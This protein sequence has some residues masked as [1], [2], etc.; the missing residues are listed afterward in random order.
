MICRIRKS[1]WSK[2][3]AMVL[4]VQLVLP[5][6]PQQV[7]A[8][9]G[10]P[11]QPE[12]SSFTP[13][14]VSDM[15]N[16][17]TGDF[18]YNI[19]L[20]DV[21]GYPI[22]LSYAGGIGMEQQA[23]NV[24][25]GWT[26]NAGGAISRTMRGI[27]DDFNAEDKIIKRNNLRTNFT[28]GA[29]LTL[30]PEILGKEFNIGKTAAK[31]QTSLT[32]SVFYNTYQ[33]IGYSFSINPMLS[34]QA[35]EK[36][37]LN[38][39]LGVTANSQSGLSISP[40]VGMDVTQSVTVKNETVPF[41]GSLGLGATF[42]S[43]AGLKAISLTGGI[44]SV[45]KTV[46]TTDSEGNSKTE[47]IFGSKLGSTIPIGTTTYIPNVGTGMF[48]SSF[49]C[50]F[51]TGLEGFWANAKAQVGGYFNEQHLRDKYREFPAAGYLYADGASG[52]NTMHDFN[53]EKDGSVTEFTPHIAMA[54]AT[55]DIYNV[56]G[57]G[58]AGMYRP[59]RDP[60][61]VYDPY[62]NS[63]SA[64]GSIGAD[65]GATLYFKGGFNLSFNFN[66]SSSGKWTSDR[67]TS[68]LDYKTADAVGAST[69]LYEPFYF[70]QAGEFALT[71]EAYMDDIGDVD[72]LRIPINADGKALNTSFKRRQNVAS[73]SEG[74]LNVTP[75][76]RGRRDKRTQ[77]MSALTAEIASE[78]GIET[79][80]LHFGAMSDSNDGTS[81]A[82]S[83]SRTTQGRKDH[84]LSEITINRNDGARYVY[85]IQQY[86]H[87]QLEVSFN[88]EDNSKDCI[89][90]F[91]DI[92]DNTN[93]FGTPK[94]DNTV[95][96]KK[97]INHFFNSTEMPPYS[98]AFLLT[99]VLSADYVDI[100]G[101]GPSDDDIGKYT[102]FN[103]TRVN[104]KSDPY[105]WR[106]PY[107][108]KQANFSEGFSSKVQDNKGNYIY[109][110]KEIWEV[111]SIV[112][113][114]HV[115]E[116][117]YSPRKD[118]FDADGEDGGQGDNTLNKLDSVKLFTKCDRVESGDQAV[119]LKTVH[120]EYDYSLCIG[121]PSNDNSQTL[122]GN[123]LSNGGG[124]LTL[125]KVY[126]TYADSKKGQLSPYQFGYA[127]SNHDLAEETALNPPYG[128]R[129]IDRWGNYKEN[130]GGGTPSCDIDHSIPS[131]AEFP[132]V[133]QDKA[134]A[135]INTAA[136]CMSTIQ[137]PSGGIIKV[138][139]ESD[140]YA[141][142]QNKRATSMIKIL[143]FANNSTSTKAALSGKNIL[144]NESGGNYSNFEYIYFDASDAS[145]L[146]D[147]KT[148]YIGDGHDQIKHLYYKVL[149]RI[150]GDAYEFLPGYEEIQGYGF[151]AGTTS[152][153]NVGWVK[154]KPVSIKD[155][156]KG[157]SIHPIA[158]SF[159]QYVRI[160]LPEKLVPFG[161][162]DTQV[163]P[164]LTF[165]KYIANTISDIK[166]MISGVNKH[167]AKMHYGREAVL[168]KSFIRL[169]K[170]D[171]NK[172]GGGN[173]VARIAMN[174]NWATMSGNTTADFDYGHTYEYK[175]TI[176]N[177][178]NSTIPNG[179]I[180]SSGVAIYEPFMGNDENPCRVPVVINEVVRGAPD[181]S[182]YQETPY[183][184]SFF[185]SPSVGYSKVI[186]TSL[187]RKDATSGAVNVK[188]TANGYV[189]HEYYTAKDFPVRVFKPKTDSQEKPVGLLGKVFKLNAKHYQ[190]IS[191]S[192][193]IEL[194]DMNGKEKSKWVYAEGQ[195][196]PVSG[197]EHFYKTKNNFLSNKLTVIDN[198]GN[199]NTNARGGIEVDMI[200][201]ERESK[202]YTLS[203]FIPFNIDISPL[204]V[205]GIPIP[206]PSA[207]PKGSQETTRFR[208]V[209][210]TKIVTR[211]AVKDSV[212]KYDLGSRVSTE[213]LAWDAE[214]GEVI[215]TKTRN[216]FNDPIYSFRYP[217]HWAY[218]RMGLSYKNLGA[219]TTL[220]TTGTPGYF[221]TVNADNFYVPGDEVLVN[222]EKYWI[223]A[224]SNIAVAIKDVN[225]EA[226]EISG[227]PTM[228][229]IRSGRRNQYKTPVGSVT[230]L[231][232]PIETGKLAFTNVLNAGSVR[233]KEGWGDFCECEDDL[234][235][236]NVY[237]TGKKGNFRTH[238]AYLYLTDR[239]QTDVNR[240]TNIRKDG[241]FET[242]QE[243]WH[244]P[245]LPSD[246]WTIDKANWSFVSEV[247]LFSPYGY[248]LENKDALGRY[249]AADYGY[250]NSLP[251][252][253]A[254]NARYKEI[255]TDNFEDYKCTTCPDDH[256]SF[257]ESVVDDDDASISES[258][259]HTGRRSIEVI[260]GGSA[261]V[262]KILIPCE[263]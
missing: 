1:R 189:Q 246:P 102:V 204:P 136:W 178:S 169:Q 188:R 26:I 10:G 255:G 60:G 98:T 41:Q 187:V 146:S 80:I 138:D 221:K 177:A 30:T 57:Q 12:F 105:R 58:V 18:K 253:V 137:L 46:T 248:E 183:G 235:S 186:V 202:Q 134:E 159:I 36:L 144:Y 63:F 165:L 83:F 212:V 9:T 44:T 24:G 229:V 4:M 208:S 70:K 227:D 156:G 219:E 14:G 142:V 94:P 207:W 174:D 48:S 111:Q 226:P 40:K 170:P 16:L 86:N 100:K 172:L 56:S 3:I 160:N 237:A 216:N 220:E 31:L 95:K 259:S 11:S 232:N 49:S 173:R 155:K 59:F 68:D 88:V 21:G 257:K 23:T 210:T 119:A 99:S 261:E 150:E 115:A 90:G 184:E 218:D 43:R 118:A 203:A 140:D 182:F 185:P 103:Y 181:N 113:K 81:T 215:L 66:K 107:G 193:V 75:I 76:K 50:N 249:A 260:A 123:E 35:T 128:F 7:M 245:L 78:V 130:F 157:N 224:V 225:G 252:T 149:L 135:D 243:F 195:S 151:N 54:Q 153:D 73:T 222:G 205:F 238:K 117:Y 241:T 39:N 152:A 114:T 82:H 244:P 125:K 179:T 74:T 234:N 132:Y 197:F 148:K 180:V 52:K 106:N 162:E 131:N 251:V 108:Y 47:P 110:E 129:D 121:I 89:N 161:D 20:L 168:G 211:Y 8:V 38:A 97:G 147:F 154:L 51:G 2:V 122:A 201:D 145:S 213:N 194:N 242:F 228:R 77:P 247:T 87:K 5:L 96:N 64:G 32:F 233:F 109:G 91:V 164:A 45:H 65:V 223:I 19:P 120:F 67:P 79:E 101:D 6:L 116:F 198:S 69:S 62:V 126:F 190:T 250:N 214:T 61:K 72:A 84:H 254:T 143:G 112:T 22:N 167:L 206:I 139:F 192:H 15:V 141:Y 262:E 196:T 29:S 199:V 166:M 217:A 55:Y 25:L 258:E 240:N 158:K 42:S 104:S 175:T 33:G 176:E 171:F 17:F 28:G 27:P 133:K 93:I 263:D 236:E 127:D 124:K 209:A 191:Q 163:K 200:T 34:I 71:D 13:V 37:K 239:V 231:T 230:T 256:F 53:R 92:L 85:G